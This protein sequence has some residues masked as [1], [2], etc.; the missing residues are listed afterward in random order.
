MKLIVPFINRFFVA[1]ARTLGAYNEDD[2]QWYTDRGTAIDSGW[3]ISEADCLS[4]H[5]RT[6][7]DYRW[8]VV[9][10]AVIRMQSPARSC[11]GC[12]AP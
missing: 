6:P 5:E 10:H 4:N 12:F 8:P 1:S 7:G 3:G 2:A 9:S 11:P